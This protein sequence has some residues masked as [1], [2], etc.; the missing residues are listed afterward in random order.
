MIH[1]TAEIEDGA[2][3]GEGTLIWHLCHVRRGAVIGRDCVL[4]RGVFV[5]SGVSIGDR[6]K[7]QNY[8]SMFHGV[9]IEDGAF[10]GPHVCFTNDR[11]PRAV[12]PDMSLK[13]ADDWVLTETR[14]RSGA[15]IGAGS[16]IVCGVTIGRWALVGAASVVTRDVAEYAVVV[17]SPARQIGYVCACGQRKPSL[18]AARDC[19]GCQR[20]AVA[21]S[22]ERT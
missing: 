15:S 4:G 9:S 16:T 12:N 10:I 19:P 17:G 18:E 11:V 20:P 7:I 6:V 21:S 13:S 8:V 3:V 22:G 2:S 5:D 14:V 1:K